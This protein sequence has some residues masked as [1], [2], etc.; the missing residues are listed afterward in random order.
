MYCTEWTQRTTLLQVSKPT[1]STQT[2]CK[3]ALKAGVS[4]EYSISNYYFPE[5]K[6]NH[7]CH[8]L[9]RSNRATC[10]VCFLCEWFILGETVSGSNTDTDIF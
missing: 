1:L 10:Y 6:N 5:E 4:Q 2:L 3:T 8:T 9:F 7:Y